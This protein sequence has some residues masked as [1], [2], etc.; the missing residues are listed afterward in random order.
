MAELQLLGPLVALPPCQ[1]SCKPWQ[2]C[3][4]CN[5]SCRCCQMLC[6]LH[7]SHSNGYLALM[8]STGRG[9]RL[10]RPGSIIARCGMQNTLL[11][12]CRTSFPIALQAIS[13]S[14][15]CLFCFFACVNTLMCSWQRACC[16]MHLSLV[17]GRVCITDIRGTGSAESRMTE[18]NLIK[19]M[20]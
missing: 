6:Q 13:L 18:V 1:P 14:C 9:L 17:Q 7:L 20:S 15:F 11:Q 2:G 16:V 8:G 4:Q 10:L 12:K 5:S 3:L 19:I